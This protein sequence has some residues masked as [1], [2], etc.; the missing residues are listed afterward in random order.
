MKTLTVRAE[1]H[2]CKQTLEF[3]DL[4][5]VKRCAIVSCKNEFVPG[6]G[7]TYHA[8][9]TKDAER[10][11]KWLDAIPNGLINNITE[12]NFIC[13]LHFRPE[14][15]FDTPSGRNFLKKDAVPSSFE[16]LPHVAS[17]KTEE[18]MS[19]LFQVAN[20]ELTVNPRNKLKRR[21]EDNMT[22]EFENMRADDE[23]NTS[24][25]VAHNKSDASTQTSPKQSKP[26]PRMDILANKVDVLQKRLRRRDAKISIM[27]DVIKSLKENSNHS[28][29]IQGILE[30]HFSGDK[31]ELLLNEVNNNNVTPNNRQYSENIKQFALTMY[32]FSP[33]AYELLRK[34]LCFPHPG[35]M[36]KW[37]SSYNCDSVKF[38]DREQSP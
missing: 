19:M 34:Y 8:F 2:S 30:K 6:R 18:I 12:T 15:Y 10:K 9:P 25:E 5:M 23:E 22:D 11:K 21:V 31:L 14:N 20:N 29:G 24:P 17:K 26:T 32:C 16:F 7:V 28:E 4:K 38:S 27:E 1:K 33:K 13:S 36:R 3:N 37:I 35:T